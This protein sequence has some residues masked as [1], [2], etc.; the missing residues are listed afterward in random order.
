LDLQE[1]VAQL[2]IHERLVVTLALL[3]QVLLQLVQ[4]VQ[5]EQQVLVQLVLVQ[6]VQE[7]PIVVA[8]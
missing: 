1:L 6:L 2:Q 7:K 5:V 3:Q 4:Q 8:L